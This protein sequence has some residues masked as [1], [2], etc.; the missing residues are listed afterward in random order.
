[1]DHARGGS[2]PDR[3]INIQV[4]L[5]PNL[6]FENGQQHQ[7]CLYVNDDSR[8]LYFTLTW[9]GPPAI[10]P[11]IRR[12]WGVVV[13]ISRNSDGEELNDRYAV[14]DALDLA[15]V[16]IRD[17]EHGSKDYE[18]VNFNLVL[19]PWDMQRSEIDA[20]LKYGSV[21]AFAPTKNGIVQGVMD[22][23]ERMRAA[24]KISPGEDFFI[25]SFSG[26]GAS[27]P[28]SG[29]EALFATRDT[30]VALTR[31]AMDD[32]TIRTSELFHLLDH[33]PGRK[34][35][36]LDACRTLLAPANGQPFSA[37]LT[38][39]QLIEGLPSAHLFISGDAGQGSFEEF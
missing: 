6:R 24:N 8:D 34:L 16:F 19:S 36:L 17:H 33:V 26:H 32:T 28:W 39:R 4:I 27:S 3:L 12:L 2:S 25:F 30:P 31:D 5:P 20:I 13:G 15:Q 29:G 23:A 18:D 35:V 22:I 7:L 38:K 37:A 11:R 9:T 14:N 21:K 10:R 1:M